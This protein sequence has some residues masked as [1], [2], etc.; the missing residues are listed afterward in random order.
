MRQNVCSS[1]ERVIRTLIGLALLSLLFLLSPPYSYFGWLGLVP[2]ATAIFKYCPIS[3]M[4]GMD[5]CT[6]KHIHS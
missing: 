1:T 5:T 3:H 6:M 4:L 2:L